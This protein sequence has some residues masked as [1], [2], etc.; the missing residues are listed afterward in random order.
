MNVHSVRFHTRLK[1]T[2]PSVQCVFMWWSARLNCY[3]SLKCFSEF[4][5]TNK[6]DWFTIKH[7]EMRVIVQMGLFE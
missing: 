1:N 3:E 5:F 4:G 7:S 2:S 6:K